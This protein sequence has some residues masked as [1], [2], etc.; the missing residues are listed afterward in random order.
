MEALGYIRVSTEEQAK[1]GVSLAAQ[2]AR[3]RAY[4]TAAGLTLVEIMRDEGVSASKPLDKRPAGMALMR[5]LAR[6]QARH[7]VVVTLDRMFRSTVDCLSKVE[8][9]DRAGIGL[10]LVDHGGQSIATATAVGRMF[11]TMLAGFAEMERKLN[12]ERTAAA[13][14]H[15]KGQRQAYS[16]TPYGFDR[17]GDGLVVNATEQTIIEQV[18]QWHRQGSSLHQIAARL[19]AAGVPTKRGGQWH[20]CTVRY[21]LRNELYGEV[22]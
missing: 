16:P 18:Q 5:A 22:A 10:H 1:E 15:K 9:W 4:C 13:L 19:T 7:V 8:T 2:E 21:L 17:E 20:A 12:G 14:R 11:L 6:K 3:L